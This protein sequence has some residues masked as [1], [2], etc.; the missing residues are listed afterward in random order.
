[1]AFHTQGEM[2]TEPP[3][4]GKPGPLD[5]AAEAREAWWDAV[6]THTRQHRHMWVPL[7][8]CPVSQST[9]SNYRRNAEQDRGT[10]PKAFA[11]PGFQTKSVEGVFYARLDSDD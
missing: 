9:V 3:Q 8:N 4:F 11:V 5:A 1:M 7:L 2:W 6:L 10:Y